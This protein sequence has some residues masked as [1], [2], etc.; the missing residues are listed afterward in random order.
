MVKAGDAKV[1]V[2]DM[3]ERLG[4]DAQVFHSED[5]PACMS[6]I[7]AG[8][9]EAAFAAIQAGDVSILRQMAAPEAM[10]SVIMPAEEE[11]DEDEDEEAPEERAPGQSSLVSHPMV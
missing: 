2:I 5:G 1:D 3:L 6:E 7:A 8:V 9:D 11:D 10:V 4:T